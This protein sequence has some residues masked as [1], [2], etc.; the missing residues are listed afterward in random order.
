MDINDLSNLLA[1]ARLEYRNC[2]KAT[3]QEVAKDAIER[4]E[5]LCDVAHQHVDGSWWVIYSYPAQLV[6]LLSDADP[7]LPE[8]NPELASM[9]QIQVAYLHMLED[10][11]EAAEALLAESNSEATT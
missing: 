8:R 5:D 6:P 2:V 3:A 7:D 11:M 1:P 9:W 10:V 4:E